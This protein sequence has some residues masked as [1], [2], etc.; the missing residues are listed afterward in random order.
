MHILPPY[1]RLLLLTEGQL[2]VFTSKTAAV[3]MKY[4]PRDVVAVIDAPAAGRRLVE[5]IP[6]A[7][8]VPILADVAR[9]RGLQPDAMFIGI[10]PVGG[11]LPPGMRAH[12]RAALEAGIDVVSGLHNFLADDPEL[13]ALAAASGAAITDLRRPPADRAVASAKALYTRCR[14][15]LTV[16]T[17]CNVGKMVTALEL[18]AATNQRVLDARFLATGQTGIMIAGRGICIDACVADFAAGA[19]E[20]LALDAG[21]SDVC[22]IEGQ[23]SLGHPGF[24][25]VTLA[26]LHGTCPDALVLVHQLGR[27]QYKA[28]PHRELPPIRELILAYERTAALLHPARVAAVALNSI[29]YPL[30][31]A[32]AAADRLEHELGVPVADPVRDGCD[33]LLSKLLP[34]P[35]GR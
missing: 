22:F 17:D 24:S 23:G 33:R 8:E 31:E 27:A 6:W 32:R 25:G 14:R 4:R 28:E 11:A 18:T 16:G 1:R 15:V 2:G 35:G 26:L 34:L 3:V 19:A 29:G 21:T 20:Q 5:F 30:E 10:A 12:V 9:A 7:P 13:A